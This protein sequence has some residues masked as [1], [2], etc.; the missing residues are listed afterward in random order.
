KR[1][2]GEPNLGKA[3]LFVGLLDERKGVAHLLQAFK[4]VKEKIKDLKLVMIGKGPLYEKIVQFAKEN[5]LENDISLLGVVSNERMPDYFRAALL[6]VIPS[7]TTKKWEEQVGMA[8]IQSMAC[9]TPVVSTFSGAIPEYVKHGRTGIL[10]PEKDHESLAV[11]IIKLLKDEKYRKKLGR[12][13]RKYAVANYDLR[14]TMKK[15]EEIVL[16]LL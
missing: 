15:N 2:G 6:T 5:R 11:A 10:V 9:G 3:I 14:K 4:K 8:N 12:N 13:A 1:T 16:N 7:I